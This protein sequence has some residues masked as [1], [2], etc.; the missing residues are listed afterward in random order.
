[1]FRYEA[2]GQQ[3][4]GQAWRWGTPKAVEPALESYRPG[5]TREISYDPKDPEEIETNLRYN[6]EFFSVP[7]FS[8]IFGLA[9]MAGSVS[10]YRW[11]Y[12]W[13]AVSQRR[14]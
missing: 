1:V 3:Y 13:K 2:Q 12:G 8:A 14:D 9:L 5:T 7:A 6:W 10:I 4:I 11:S